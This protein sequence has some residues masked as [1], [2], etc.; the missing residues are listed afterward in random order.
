MVRFRHSARLVANAG[1]SP[2]RLASSCYSNVVHSWVAGTSTCNAMLC[3]RLR[4]WRSTVEGMRETTF[5]E[6][7]GVSANM[8]ALAV[9]DFNLLASGVD[10]A[11]RSVGV[12]ALPGASADDAQLS[13][14]VLKQATAA[15]ARFSGASLVQLGKVDMLVSNT[16]YAF[17]SSQMGLLFMDKY[18]TLWN[19]AVSTAADLVKAAHVICH[20]TGHQWFGGLLQ[21][22]NETGKFFIE[23]STTSFGEVFCANHA[24]PQALGNR[25]G[26]ERLFFPPFEDTQSIHVGAEFHAMQNLASP[27]HANDSI[28]TSSAVFYTKG[29]AFLHMLEDYGNSAVHKVCCASC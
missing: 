8:L 10:E 5:K 3:L 9:G 4:V 26:F 2:A 14:H 24:L 29:P 15:W 23:E 28:L 7:K 27:W 13:L 6:I 21:T 1:A 17:S 12:W 19:P 20:E 16:A 18:R 11:G 22:L 25:A